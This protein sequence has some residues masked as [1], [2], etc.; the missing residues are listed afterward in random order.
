MKETRVKGQVIA[1]A[2]VLKSGAGVLQM[3]LKARIESRGK[4]GGGWEY[5]AKFEKGAVAAAFLH[6][7]S[8]YVKVPG[9]APCSSFDLDR[10]DASRSLCSQHAAR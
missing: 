4:K 3:I 9:V 1:V 7:A 5:R 6:P 10:R 8:V 2:G